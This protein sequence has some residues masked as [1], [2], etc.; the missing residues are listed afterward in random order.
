[1]ART[2]KF[3]QE[4]FGIGLVADEVTEAELKNFLP[5]EEYDRLIS[6]V[7]TATQIINE[8]SRDLKKLRELGLID[9]F[10]TY[11][12]GE[13][14]IRFLCASGQM[15]THQEVPVTK[16]VCQYEPLFLSVFFCSYF[17]LAWFQNS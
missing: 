17:P 16:A 15:R 14:V 12:N 4:K 6:N 10:S 5:P 1:M 8:Q 2:A 9:D 3:Y 13:A 7:N 11:G